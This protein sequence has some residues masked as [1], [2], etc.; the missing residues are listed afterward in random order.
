LPS[1]VI[2][3]GFPGSRPGSLFVSGAGI[4]SDSKRR[5]AV[6]P[7]KNTEFGKKV[8]SLPH[9]PV[10]RECAFGIVWDNILGCFVSFGAACML[11]SKP[12]PKGLCSG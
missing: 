10:N 12:V 4:V 3:A 5:L 7:S 11:A 2:I 9:F 1:G 8:L 6:K